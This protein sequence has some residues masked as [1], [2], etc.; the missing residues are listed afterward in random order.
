MSNKTATATFPAA[1]VYPFNQWYV[2]AFSH[3]VQEEPL[4]RTVLGKPV[5]LFRLDDGKVIALHDRCPHRGLPL[6]LGKRRGQRV[7]CGYHGLQFDA[8]GAC[9]G[10]PQQKSIPSS[11][12]VR[13]YPVIEKWQWLWIWMG[14]PAKAD[15]SLLP[16]HHAL[17]VASPGYRAIPCFVLNM[18]ANCQL[19]HDNLLDTSHLSYLHPGLLDTGEM[20]SSKFWTKDEGHILR[21][22]RDTPNVR[23]PGPLAAYFKIKADYPYDRT[24]T[25]EAHLP[26]LN[27]AR[28]T[29]RDPADPDLPPHEL[30]AINCL[31]P[32]SER[33]THVFHAEVTSYEFDW[34]PEM[35]AGVK[36][37]VMQD[38][39][40]VE[41]IQQR[42]DQYGETNEVSL[43]TDQAGVKSRRI[44]SR[45]ALVEAE[46]EEGRQLHDTA[47]V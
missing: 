33:S 38:K 45:M 14:D 12:C 1:Q 32:E 26:H 11:M 6:S 20:A 39:V 7:Q 22:G 24:L 15:E 27:V 30:F 3:E 25:V 13:S 23:F 37:I 17:G 9:V 28:Q 16:D 31:T 40:A 19:M 42:Y 46:E 29:I 36:H 18:Q 21:L 8:S 41:A 4:A 43:M 35:I 10:I 47:A 5:A 44:I 2:A 34:T